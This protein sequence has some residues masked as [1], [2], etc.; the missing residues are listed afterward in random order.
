MNIP[1]LALVA[2][3]AVAG[4]WGEPGGLSAEPIGPDG[5]L[6]ARLE[7]AIPADWLVRL[8]GRS[9]A[10]GRGASAESSLG[11]LTVSRRRITNVR[12]RA[13]AHGVVLGGGRGRNSGLQLK[14]Q[15]RKA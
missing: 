4:L 7:P 9:V 11:A 1:T 15:R 2:T 5:G 3:L 12:E 10:S 13:A 14:G 6:R 8:E